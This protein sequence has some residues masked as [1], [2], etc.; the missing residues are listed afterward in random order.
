MFGDRGHFIRELYWYTLSSEGKPSYK[1]P[2]Q[3]LSMFLSR[4]GSQRS[5]ALSL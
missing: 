1:T 2:N 5:L 3:L 4:H